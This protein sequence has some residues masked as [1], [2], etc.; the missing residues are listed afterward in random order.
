M[1]RCWSTARS[2]I[3]ATWWSLAFRRARRSISRS[4]T[5]PT[6]GGRKSLSWQGRRRRCAIAPRYRDQ[7]E[8]PPRAF[9]PRGRS[10][11]AWPPRR[12][13]GRREGRTFHR[14]HLHHPPLPRRCAERQSRFSRRPTARLRIDANGWRPGRIGHSRQEKK[15]FPLL[16][17]WRP[18]QAYRA[19]AFRFGSESIARTA[20]VLG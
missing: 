17:D 5:R 6:F 19:R 7:P 20:L 1:Q 9:L 14:S 12:S 18:S 4:P 8:F 15:R 10:G 11:G 2:A 16:S 3:S 13:A